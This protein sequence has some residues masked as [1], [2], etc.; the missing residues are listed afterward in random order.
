MKKKTPVM[1]KFRSEG[2]EADWWASRAGRAFV[3]QKAAEAQSKGTTVRGLSL[4][5]KLNQKSSIQIA[6][7]LPEAD[8]ER[9]RKIADRK[10]LG[11]QTLLK[12]LVHEGLRREARR[13]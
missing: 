1:P 13:G 8:I 10:G 3:K 9:A 12:M 4:V 6:L 2:E 5:R 11:Y 7:R